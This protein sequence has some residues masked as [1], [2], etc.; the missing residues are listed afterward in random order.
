MTKVVYIF[1]SPRSGSTLLSLI[2]GNHRAVANI[3]EVSFIPKL[4]ALGEPC[5]CLA[6]LNTCPQWASVFNRLRKEVNIDM[7]TNP[8]QLWLGDAIKRGGGKKDT[9]YQTRSRVAKAKFRAGCE[10]LELSVPSFIGQHASMLPWVNSSVKNTFTLYNAVAKEWAADVL[11]DASKLTRKGIYLYRSNPDNVRLIQLVR[12]GRGVVASRSKHLS[13][14][15]AAQQWKRYH[16][17]TDILVER[18]VGSDHYTKIRYE[19]F[20]ENPI[21]RIND[22]CEWI[23]IPFYE[24][25]LKFS[26]NQSIHSAGGNPTRFKA[27]DGI[28]AVDDSW[29]KKLSGKDLND[30]S[31]IAGRLNT[32]YGYT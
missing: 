25:I 10:H 29:R 5:T 15:R 9:D 2:L 32:A 16:E 12:D 14:T 24:S 1:S 13:I 17:L 19:D 18:W 26:G 31:R 8:Y 3:G 28:R 6:P 4:L 27:D 21:Q 20:V 11:V 23:G 7:R 30:F 22:I